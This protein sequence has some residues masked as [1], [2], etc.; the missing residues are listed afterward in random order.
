MFITL[1]SNYS[2]KI[3]LVII[4]VTL[5]T[6]KEVIWHQIVEEIKEEEEAEALFH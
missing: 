1:Y 4:N 2:R 6:E 5:H 3:S